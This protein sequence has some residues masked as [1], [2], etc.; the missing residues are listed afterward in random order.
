[1]DFKFRF[2]CIYIIQSLPDNEKQTGADLI[3]LYFKN[4]LSTND[5]FKAIESLKL[6]NTRVPYAFFR[7][8]KYGT[9]TVT[10]ILN[11][12]PVEKINEQNLGLY[13]EIP[14]TFPDLNGIPMLNLTQY[15][16][17]IYQIRGS[18]WTEL[19]NTLC[20][21]PISFLFKVEGF[22]TYE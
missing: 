6:S 16:K 3:N 17:A 18:L 19:K 7:L 2:N 1:M 15:S 9:Y 4:L 13:I 14:G 12:F 8:S 10:L 21:V 22:S 11:C 20:S 5:F